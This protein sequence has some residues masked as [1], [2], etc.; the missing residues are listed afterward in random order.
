M[1][2]NVVEHRVDGKIMWI[3]VKIQSWPHSIPMTFA[4]A[5]PW[6]VPRGTRYIQC[7]STQTSSR[8]VR[9]GCARPLIPIRTR[10]ETK[11]EK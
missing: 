8:F 4:R 7:I 1:K 2:M 11:R 10:K 6:S 3:D 5:A 9:L